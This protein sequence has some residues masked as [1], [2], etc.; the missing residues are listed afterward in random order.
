VS[1]IPEGSGPTDAPRTDR[2]P[3]GQTVTRKWPV[4]HS[5]SVPRIDPET[6]RFE[7]TGLVERPL[8]LRWSDLARF[9]RVE[10]LCDIHCVTQWSRYDTRFG[11]ISVPAILAECR[12]APEARFVMVSA[13]PGYTTNLPLADLDRP[14][15]LLATHYAGEPLAAEHGGPIRLVVPHL[16]FWKSAKWV[17]GFELMDE[18]RPGYWEQNGYHML[19]DPWREQ[20]YGRPDPVRMRRGPR[21]EPGS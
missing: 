14:E 4:L 10:S 1:R 20:R 7:V 17:T 21:G 19:G 11:G 18:D 13:D 8:S 5:G 2:L 9:P 15:N 16:Y 3:P 12:P 6:W